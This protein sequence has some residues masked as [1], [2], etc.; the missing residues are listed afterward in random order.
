MNATLMHAAIDW[1]NESQ[2][3]SEQ[4]HLLRKQLL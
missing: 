3:H 4:P 1:T 2:R